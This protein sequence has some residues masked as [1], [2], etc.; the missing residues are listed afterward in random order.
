MPAHARRF[1]D[2]LRGAGDAQ[3]LEQL[4]WVVTSHLRSRFTD[5]DVDGAAVSRM[6]DVTPAL[7]AAPQHLR[8]ACYMHLHLAGLGARFSATTRNGTHPSD[9]W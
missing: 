7:K 9:A 5:G 6:A 1:E 2:A 4:G 3:T 8:A